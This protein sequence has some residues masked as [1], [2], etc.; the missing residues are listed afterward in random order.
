MSTNGYENCV[1]GTFYGFTNNQNNTFHPGDTF[2][3]QWGAI[4]GGTKSLNISLARQ[5]GA[6]LSQI[7]VGAV[8][9][10]SSNLYRLVTNKTANC[11]LEQYTW[12]IP[13]NFNTTNPQYQFGLFDASAKLGTGGNGLYGWLAWSPFFYVRDK[14][15]VLMT[16]T[17]TNALLTGTGTAATLTASASTSA[18][19]TP[20]DGRT[21]SSNSKTLGIGV[22]V[23]VGGAAVILLVLLAVFFTRRRRRK[24]IPAQGEPNPT[25][26]SGMPV[27]LPG[28]E[29]SQGRKDTGSNRL[30]EMPG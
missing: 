14:S 18:T 2:D 22:G 4:D 12:T 23:G 19:S 30:Y 1:A 5:G 29:L 8:F 21:D 27:E 17:S 28:Q 6:L 16:S 10:T 25:E 11:T 15:N 24:Y 20:T 26:T 9:N 13:T 3:L 7:A